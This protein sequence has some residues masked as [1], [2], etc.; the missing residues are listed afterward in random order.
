[1]CVNGEEMKH[2]RLTKTP[3]TKYEVNEIRIQHKIK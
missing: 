3:Y 1:M 2:E